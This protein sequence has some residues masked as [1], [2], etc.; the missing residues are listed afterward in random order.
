MNEPRLTPSH[1]R[2]R[3]AAP[4]AALGA[5]LTIALSIPFAGGCGSAA[6]GAG[7]AGGATATGTATGTTTTSSTGSSGNDQALCQK[8]MTAFCMKLFQCVPGGT[9]K[10]KT[11]ADCE[12]Q[13]GQT[14]T[15]GTTCPLDAAKIDA[16]V[17][18]LGALACTGGN[19]MLPPTCDAMNLCQVGGQ[20]YCLGQSVDV[21]GSGGGGGSGS[22]C[23]LTLDSC[24]DGNTYSVQCG[25]TCTCTVNGQSPKVVPT[26]DYCGSGG[27]KAAITACGWN[28]YGH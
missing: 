8:M 5:A 6:G 25:A 3:F 2:I 22:Q 14:C 27:R 12:A 23:T 15:G 1:P 20:P 9:P 4:T 21:S 17:A 26:A 13:Y 11:E 19:P 16:C 24:S 18:D 7:G 10:I 28:L